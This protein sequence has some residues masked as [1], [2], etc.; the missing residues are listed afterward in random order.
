MSVTVQ[1]RANLRTLAEFLPSVD[2]DRFDMAFYRSNGAARVPAVPEC[3]TVAC[4]AGWGPVA[5]GHT[6]TIEWIGDWVREH[7]AE[8]KPWWWCFSQE[9]T[10]VDNTP[11]GAAKRILHFL[12][13]G[14]PDDW[15]EQ[16]HGGAPYMFADTGS[17]VERLPIEQYQERH[18]REHSRLMGIHEM[19][20]EYD[21][22][23]FG[24]LTDN[25][26]SASVRWICARAQARIEWLELRDANST[27]MLATK[28]RRIK[29]LEASLL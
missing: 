10:G 8:G 5:L 6:D 17:T 3:G 13:H 20:L 24:R 16:M 18:R 1:Q 23:L 26:D 4:A 19:Q 2:P 15:A 27:Q 14:L 25:D 28:T 7:L 21:P 12:D 22:F 11:T 29:E 9:W